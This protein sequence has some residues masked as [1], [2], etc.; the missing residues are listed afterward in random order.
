MALALMAISTSIRLARR[1][2][3]DR[4]QA[5]RKAHYLSLLGAHA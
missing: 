3:V 5:R 1:Q 4:R 2:Q